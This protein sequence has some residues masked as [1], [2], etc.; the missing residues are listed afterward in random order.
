LA[1]DSVA[2][3]FGGQKIRHHEVEIEAKVEDGSEAIERVTKG[4]MEMYEATLR[5]WKYSKLATGKAIEKLLGEGA[6][7]ELL[8]INNNLKPS[9]YGKIDRFFKGGGI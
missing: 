9:A 2:Y 5:P 4:L 6:L 7:E 8:D 1:I 3:S